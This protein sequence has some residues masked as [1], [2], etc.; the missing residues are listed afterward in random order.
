MKFYAHYI[1]SI[2]LL[3]SCYQS[4]TPTY[5]NTAFHN[6]VLK[7]GYTI[8]DRVATPE[9]YIRKSY[10]SESFANYLQHLPL[11]PVN[12]PVL[13]FKGSAIDIQ[14][15]HCAVVSMD[16]G[17]RDLQ[18]CADAVIRLRAEY[19][20]KTK[21]F[22]KIQFHFTSGDLFAWKDYANGKRVKI[23]GRKVRFVDTNE[24][25][26]SYQ[27][28]RKY[29]DIVFMYAG[30]VS[31]YNESKAVT[32]TNDITIGDFIITPGSPGHTAIVVDECINSEGKKLYLLAQ[33]FMPAQNIHVLT[34]PYNNRI[35]PWY[36]VN[37]GERILTARYLFDKGIVHR[38]K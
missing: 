5:S 20:F 33:S 34:N 3:F 1:A 2:F 22:D 25:S 7:Q 16:I 9:G 21:Q 12:A 17:N 26:N 10:N 29:L 36:E 11:K 23:T 14:D 28:F 18:Q 27:Q 31:I 38:F 32:N 37:V 8:R 13:D 24:K 19:L 30:T 4:T 35:S 6:H 15:K